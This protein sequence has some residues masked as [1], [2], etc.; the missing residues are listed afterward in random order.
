MRD[1][2]APPPRRLT[3]HQMVLRNLLVEAELGDKLFELALLNFDLLH[4]PQLANAEPTINVLSPVKGLIGK[5]HPPDHFRHRRA[6]LRFL[7]A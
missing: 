1:H 7:S 5:A 2:F 6:R 3:F 4:A